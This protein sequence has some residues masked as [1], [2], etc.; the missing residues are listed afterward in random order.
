VADHALIVG[1][2]AYPNLAGGNLRGAVADAL[3]VR[4]WLSGDGRSIAQSQLTFLASCSAEGAEADPAVVDGA[5]ARPDFAAAVQRLV[6]EPGVDEGDWLFVYLAGHG[7]RTDPQNPVLAQDAFAFTDFRTNDPSA[8]CM[9]VQDLVSRLRQSRFGVVVVFLD[10]CRNFPFS[11]PFQLGGLGLDPEPPSDRRYEP[12]LF[13]LHSTLPGH[14]STG[15]ASGEPSGT[16]R[17]DFTVALLDGLRGAGTAKTYDETRDRPYTVRWSSLTSFLE[18]ALPAQ[19]PRAAGEGELILA[20]F[21]EGHFDAVKLTVVVDPRE[22]GSAD[23]LRVHVTYFDPSAAHEPELMQPGPVPVE[24][25]VPPRLQRV[26]AEAGNTWGK[27]SF[28]VYANTNVVVPLHRGGPPSRPLPPGSTVSR[29]GRQIAAGAVQ[30]GTDDPAAVLRIQDR[31]G[32]I[33]LSGVGTAGGLLAPGPYMVMLI[34]GAGRQHVEHVD[35]DAQAEVPVWIPAPVPPTPLAA[36]GPGHQALSGPL[37]FASDAAALGWQAA[38]L[39]VT[40]RFAIA[41]AGTGPQ[42][43]R[44][45]I[46]YTLEGNKEVQLQEF[47]AGHQPWWGF[48]LPH[49]SDLEDSSWF[50]IHLAD[51]SLTLPYLPGASTTAALGQDRLI[52]ALFDDAVLHSE[53]GLAL[54][55]RSQSLLGSGE[56]DAV[57]TLL[58]RLAELPESRDFPV[59]PV[60]AHLRAAADPAPTENLAVAVAPP[61]APHLLPTDTWAVFVDF[62]ADRPSTATSPLQAPQPRLASS[63]LEET[64]SSNSRDALQADAAKRAARHGIGLEEQRRED[65]PG[66]V[67]S[68]DDIQAE[69]DK[70]GTGNDVHLEEQRLADA[71]PPHRASR[72][73][74]IA[75]EAEDWQDLLGG[76]DPR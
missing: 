33:V 54:M 5:A 34:D 71:Q 51:H 66:Q 39:G 15:H 64:M 43:Q 28:D 42:P 18:D 53:T 25:T 55:D 56:R 32:R 58:D 75:R 27:H 65:E 19:Q 68:R 72:R 76:P 62:P 4:D 21:P 29:D 12:R 31:S 17:G 38:H 8:A 20:S 30:V 45:V 59:G 67:A 49:V 7:C 23:D 2:D 73:R 22:L 70:M 52:V 63:G 9:G 57:S 10:A 13:L 24:F 40:R 41:I 48:T 1:C 35:V 61:D 74:R 14:T 47:G 3:A 36:L 50:K 26:R 44:R 46:A 37:R 60:A 16:V 69:L 11:Q 6:A